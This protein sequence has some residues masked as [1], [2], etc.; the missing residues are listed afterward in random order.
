MSER[1][2]D[3]ETVIDR[4]NTKSLKYDFAVKRGKPAD[5]LPLWVADMDFRTSSYIED[6]L[7]QSARHGVFGYTETDEEYFD[8]VKN[9]MKTQYDWDISDE[10]Q[11]IKTP[12]IV[13]ALAAAVNCYT[14]PGD[15]VL[16]NS[17]VYYPFSEVISDNGRRIVSSDLVETEDLSYRIDFDDFEKKI[18]DNHIKLYFLCNP[19][20]P[21]SK[22]WSREELER[23]GEICVKH[24]VTV[25][26]Y[27]IHADFEWDKKHIVFASLSP[28]IAAI[29][30]TC[31][32][33]TKTFNIAGLQISNIIITDGKLRNKFKHQV[34]AFGFSQAGAAGIYS[35]EAAY[36]NG[37]VWLK[38]VKDYI[39][40]NIE[41]T[42][43][44]I[45]E[46]LPGVK[47]FQTQATYLVWVDFRGT[48]L[49]DEE[50]D[51]RI[52][53]KAGLWLDSGSIFGDSGRGFQRIN[54]ACPRAILT[55][56]LERLA[57]AF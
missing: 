1:N 49:S 22:S 26:S 15:P 5:I 7:I 39:K 47:V 50:I 21:G 42:K 43:S 56:A 44:F 13:F 28:E 12:G 24:G 33:P 45:E 32:S 2:L 27:E 41:Y 48:G 40:S 55:E 54:V 18:V 51:D 19:H 20:N 8:A 11:L 9:W 34:N 38:A 6:A 25:V 57:V 37:D 4:R 14:E 17:P 31:T 36:K 10:R 46:K 52:I 29:T 53:N 16:I 35:C 3:F 23:I 30:V